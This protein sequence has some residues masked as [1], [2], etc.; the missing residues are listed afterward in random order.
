MDSK[1]GYRGN[2]LLIG[3]K[4]N[5]LDYEDISWLSILYLTQASQRPYFCLLFSL[6]TPLQESS[7][8]C[9]PIPFHLENLKKYSPGS[10][11][12]SVLKIAKYQWYLNWAQLNIT[13]LMSAQLNITGN[14]NHPLPPNFYLGLLFSLHPSI[15]KLAT[16]F[17]CCC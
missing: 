10:R 13:Q 3:D 16:T 14:H 4:L 5:T 11:N 12:F 15:L 8:Q 1:S 6:I 9:T 7:P 17:F 2:S